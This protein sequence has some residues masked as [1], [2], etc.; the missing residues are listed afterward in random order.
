MI[1]NYYYKIQNFVKNPDL[2]IK[3]LLTETIAT[4]GE[5]VSIAR[6]VRFQLGEMNPSTD[7]QSDNEWLIMDKINYKRILLKISGELL[8]GTQEFGLSPMA[9]EELAKK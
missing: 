6:F 3:D 5:N 2:T 8:S 7:E 4:L 1:S 9:L